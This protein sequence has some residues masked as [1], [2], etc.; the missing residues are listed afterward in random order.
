[1]N[2]SYPVAHF[3]ASHGHE[4]IYASVSDFQN[5]IEGQGFSFHQ[6]EQELLWAGPVRFSAQRPK[7]FRQH[8]KAFQAARRAVVE[9]RS[10]LL[11]GK[12]FLT[13]I[14]S[15]QPDLIL[16]DSPFSRF[17]TTIPQTGIPFAILESMVPLNH[18]LNYP[19]LCS[20][21]VPTSSFFSTLKSQTS[22]MLYFLGRRIR[23]SLGLPTTVSKATLRKSC[24]STNFDH[25]T[26]RYDRYFHIGFSTVPE[27]LLAPQELDFPYKLRPNQHYLP[28]P[29]RVQ[30]KESVYDFA[31]DAAL[32]KLILKKQQKPGHRLVYCSLGGM[33]FRYHGVKEFYLRVL[34][35]VSTQQDI[36][37]FIS[38]GNEIDIGGLSKRYSRAQVFRRVPQL[39]LLD[40]TDLMITHGGMNSITECVEAGV[41]MLVCPGT[42]KIDQAGNAARVVYHKLGLQ[43]HL[44]KDSVTTLRKLITKILQNPQFKQNTDSMSKRM[45]ERSSQ[46]NLHTGPNALLELAE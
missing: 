18:R 41:P 7:N 19:P 29:K 36:T 27:F 34:E 23:Q 30:R 45:K 39:S 25:S 28:L 38:V 20:R 16:V 42:N 17:A 12:A 10:L 37:L 44:Q 26:I 33:S 35:A 9:K 3:L 46:T 4:V 43:A 1:M 32:E 6:L 31:F 24:R 8:L 5:T 21:S 22:W 15:L 14:E 11:S 40:H 13:E 2:A